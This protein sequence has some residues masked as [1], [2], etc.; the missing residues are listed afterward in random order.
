MSEPSYPP[1]ETLRASPFVGQRFG[2]EGPTGTRRVRGPTLFVLA[3]ASLL[4]IASIIRTLS[5]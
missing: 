1:R 5:A 3:L 2:L 4:A